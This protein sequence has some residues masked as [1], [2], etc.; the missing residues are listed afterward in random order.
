MARAFA[1][2]GRTHETL[3]TLAAEIGDVAEVATFDA[4][5]KR[6]VDEHADAWLPRVGYTCR[7]T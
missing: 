7:S 6:A 4:T 5:D 2:E 1:A 3:D